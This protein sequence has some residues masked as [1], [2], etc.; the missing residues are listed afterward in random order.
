MH[1]CYAVVTTER[2]CGTSVAAFGSGLCRVRSGESILLQLWLRHH[3][4]RSLRWRS[5]YGGQIL[6]DRNNGEE[7]IGQRS[8]HRPTFEW[9]IQYERIQIEIQRC[10][11][12]TARCVSYLL[13]TFIFITSRDTNK[14]SAISLVIS[15]FFRL[16]L[17]SSIPHNIV[18]L[19]TRY[20]WFSGYIG[21]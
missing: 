8:N 10:G 16:H 20:I 4:Q 17:F 6:R 9:R 18:W 21:Y 3:L 11:H 1:L 15:F 2:N 13:A 5:V 19:H 12:N 7:I 14:Q